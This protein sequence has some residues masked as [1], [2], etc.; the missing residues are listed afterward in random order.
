M[1]DSVQV[2]VSPDRLVINPGD[3]AQ[4]TA[5]IV[6][7]GGV[8]EVF[9]VEV[10]GLEAGWYTLS[11]PSVSLFPG[12]KEKVSITLT[13]P[14]SS[15]SAAGSY[16]VSVKVSSRRDPSVSTTAG[17]SLD[18]GKISSYELDLTPKKVRARKG[19]FEL[20]INNT[21]NITNTYQL[22]ASDPENMC[23]YEFK[24][25]TVVVEPG[26]S[27]KVPFAVAPKK[28]PFTGAAKMFAF[29]VNVTP[30]ASEVKAVQGQLECP[31]LFPK[32]ALYAVGIGVVAVIVVPIVVIVVLGGGGGGVQSWT[33]SV[34]LTSKGVKLYEL[35]LPDVGTLQAEAEWSGAAD[36]MSL[37]LFGPGVGEVD[38]ARHEGDGPLSIDYSIK[39][40]DVA[41]GDSWRVY[42]ANLSENGD[43]TAT[44]NIS[45]QP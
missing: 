21:G 32:W 19:S 45:Y 18:L 42:V 8:V 36:R 35:H 29:T 10:E 27:I 11:V 9:S 20:V 38:L 28:K 2:T 41:K 13:P 25:E 37:V 40:Q 5:E 4:A 12:D 1:S 31:P 24:S 34:K 14:S 17:L 33:E 6:N 22:E 7:A 15:S 23:S 44:V 26:T 43:A 3:R 30:V 39:S 16:D